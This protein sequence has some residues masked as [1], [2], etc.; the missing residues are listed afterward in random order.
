MSRIFYKGKYYDYPLKALERAAQPRA[1]GR[2]SCAASP[3]CWARIRPPKDQT[4][5]EGWL[6]ARFGWRLYRTFFK[7]Y[8]EKVWGVPVSE[9]PADWAA[10]RVK[11][12]DLRQGGRSTPSCPSATRRRS[13]ASSRSSSTPSTGRG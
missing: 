2:P 3:T 10:Q 12:L 1:C 5:Y 4:N 11:N 6:V 13:P 8:T 9:M 7:T